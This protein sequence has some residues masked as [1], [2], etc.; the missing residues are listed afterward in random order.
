MPGRPS[1]QS[2]LGPRTVPGRSTGRWRPRWPP[3]T[4]GAPL[5]GTSA[6]RRAVNWTDTAIVRVEAGRIKELWDT[7]I[8]YLLPALSRHRVLSVR[9]LNLPPHR[10]SYVLPKLRVGKPAVAGVLGRYAS[11]SLSDRAL[12]PSLGDLQRPGCGRWSC[13][14]VRSNG[15][16]PRHLQDAACHRDASSPVVSASRIISISGRSKKRAVPMA[17]GPPACGLA[18][19][20]SSSVTISAD[21]RSP[22]E[23]STPGAGGRRRGAAAR[24]LSQMTLVSPPQRRV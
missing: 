21:W 8:C 14:R 2:Q 1:P 17:L 13:R 22:T 10:Q 11:S 16:T 19:A 4:L 5:F 9:A 3:S 15:P 7:S 12:R 6:T 24:R 23:G 20:A 18:W